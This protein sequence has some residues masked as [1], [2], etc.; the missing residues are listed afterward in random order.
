MKT[1]NKS[2]TATGPASLFD[3]RLCGSI[4]RESDDIVAAAEID[5]RVASRT[6]HDILLAVNHV[7]GGWRV[8]AGSSAETPQF[9]AVGRIVSGELAVALT[10]ENKAAG[11][12][13]NAADH[14]LWRLH[15]PLDLAGIIIDRGNIAR[16]RLAR[17]HL[18][19]ATK[20]QLAVRIRRVLDM[21]GHRLMQV[22]GIGE[23]LPWIGRDRRPFDTTIGPRQH[24]RTFLRGQ[25]PHVLLRHHGLGETDQAAV[26][27]VVNIDVTGLA[28]MD[29]T[30]DDLAVLALDVHQHR[31]AYGIKVPDVMGDILKMAYVFAGLEIDGHQ[32]VR[33]KI[34]AGAIRSIEIR[35]WIADDK[36]E[37]VGR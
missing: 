1:A 19:G 6:D 24:A 31:R 23:S 28:G 4:E 10:R 27:A 32:R 36:I 9:L 37:P 35:R 17:D 26:L 3:D 14:R 25:H 21:V 20:P 13:E 7:S 8:D 29:H 12:G 5:L 22:D 2:G 16:L 15:L 34:V 18:E 33:I 30:R 11:G